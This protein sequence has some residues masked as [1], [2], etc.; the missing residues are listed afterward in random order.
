MIINN[1]EIRPPFGEHFQ[2]HVQETSF[3]D[4]IFTPPH[5]HD[6]I[7]VLF[8]IEG[9]YTIKINNAILKFTVDDMII[10]GS[11][12][13]HEIYQSSEGNGKYLVV[14]FQP[15]MIYS[16][17]NSALELKYVL[18]FKF[19]SLNSELIYD[20]KKEENSEIKI[21]LCNIIKEISEKKYGY[22]IAIKADIYKLILWIIRKFNSE[23][24]SMNFFTPETLKKIENALEYIEE[25]YKNNLTVREIANK[26]FM[27]Y[28]Y[29]SRIFKL[30]TSMSCC[31]YINFL[32]IKK[33]EILLLENE[34][35][36]TETATECGFDNVSYYI[37]KFKFF[38]GITPKK[39]K[40]M[41]EKKV[42]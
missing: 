40:S 26:C 28:S 3:T 34:L 14:K 18:P 25:N 9:E 10:I 15:E 11:K 33:S 32:K 39:Y 21:I 2:T 19:A 7:E 31:D 4:T 12:V 42:K 6:F 41:L 5:Y 35:T 17:Y 22:E 13:T 24:V 8:G 29:F 1:E 20:L 23:N 36:V 16:S 30:I 27:E 37:K 38:N